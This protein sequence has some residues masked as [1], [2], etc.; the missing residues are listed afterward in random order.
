MGPAAAF[1]W[2][3]TVGSLAACV[4]ICWRLRNRRK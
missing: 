2:A 1:T 4:W 3:M